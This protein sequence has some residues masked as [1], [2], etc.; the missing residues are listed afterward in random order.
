[1]DDARC[2]QPVL[3]LGRGYLGTCM[4]NVLSRVARRLPTRIFVR[5]VALQYLAF[6]PELRRIEH[7]VP[8]NLT[9]IDVGTWWGPWSWWLAR[10]VPRV[11]AFE[12]NAAICTE[13]AGALPS[14]VTLHNLALSDTRGQS[15]LWSPGTDLGTEGRSSLL[16]EG[17]EGWVQQT[18][19]T[20]PLDELGLSDVG[21]VKIDVEGF[22]LSVIKGA[23]GLLTRERPN[24]LVEIEQAHTSNEHID[25]VF[26]VLSGLG[27][28]GTFLGDDRAW[29]SLKDF[30][31]EQA[32][33]VG[34]GRKETGLL[35]NTLSRKRYINNF[36]F[37]PN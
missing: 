36:L 34:E 6:E 25:N 17:H 8:S 15:T 10:R 16:P 31:R 14:N 32:R 21:F 37:T 26:D 12:P 30:D 19:E 4:A 11:E 28:R 7:F 33:R 24:V 23:T 18:V 3:S 35:R 13:L 22:E 1:M 2:T 27:Y 5:L 9:A 29:H 20:V